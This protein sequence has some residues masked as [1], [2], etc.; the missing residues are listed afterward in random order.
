MMIILIYGVGLRRTFKQV[1][2]AR[3]IDNQ[4]GFLAPPSRSTVLPE[5]QTNDGGNDTFIFRLTEA[6]LPQCS[7]L[8]P[9]IV[10][11]VSAFVRGQLGS[12]PKQFQILLRLGMAAFAGFVR[13]RYF[14]RFSSLSLETRSKAVN[15]WAYGKTS[16]ARMLFRGIRSL[17]LLAFYEH[18]AVADALERSREPRRREMFK[19]SPS[20]EQTRRSEI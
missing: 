4:L 3:R 8:T 10:S 9:A 1:E 20:P 16:A 14:R 5:F 18:P 7:A 13:L 15:S 2:K 12:L 19:P 6:A 17:A 11:H